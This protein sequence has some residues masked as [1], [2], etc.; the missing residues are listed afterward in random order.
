CILSFSCILWF[1]QTSFYH[2][3]SQ[4]KLGGDQMSFSISALIILIY[5]GI[6]IY[7]LLKWYFLNYNIRNY[8]H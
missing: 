8:N 2:T 6:A 5:I 3:W 4:I 1:M 7:G